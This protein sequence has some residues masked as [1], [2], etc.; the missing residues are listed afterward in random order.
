[1]QLK[2][3]TIEKLSKQEVDKMI[4]AYIQKQHMDGSE[5]DSSNRQE[6][7]EDMSNLGGYPIQQNFE[8]AS[9][10]TIGSRNQSKK[11]FFICGLTPQQIKELKAAKTNMEA[12]LQNLQNQLNCNKIFLNMVIHDMRNPANAA[13]YGMTQ[14]LEIII[15]TKGLY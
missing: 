11:N 5:D 3:A 13:E 2:Q 9:C 6:T 14:S 15:E 7:M 4:E 12:T 8:A 1:M 10:Y